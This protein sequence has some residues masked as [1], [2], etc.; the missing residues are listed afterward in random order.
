MVG[1][2]AGTLLGIGVGER[3]VAVGNTGLTVGVMVGGPER[4]GG[5]IGAPIAVDVAVGVVE[6]AAGEI[7]GLGDKAGLR[8]GTGLGVGEIITLGEGLGAWVQAKTITSN[9]SITVPAASRIK[10]VFF[11]NIL[12]S[13]LKM[14]LTG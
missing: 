7:T 8:E 9:K 4:G 3:A 5:T 11:V 1:L 14:K 6:E 10:F 12:T 13:C 2:G